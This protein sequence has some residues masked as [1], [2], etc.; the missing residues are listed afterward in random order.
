MPPSWPPKRSSVVR[1]QFA[2]Q[3]SARVTQSL[4]I[5]KNRLPLASVALGFIKSAAHHL[6]KVGHR[7]Q[8]VGPGFWRQ[9]RLQAGCRPS[10][11]PPALKDSN[12]MPG[13]KHPTGIV[14]VSEA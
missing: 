5:V 6:V 7:A 9:V 13:T 4:Q 12:R 8:Q 2:H 1:P 3:F 11:R 14:C 10:L